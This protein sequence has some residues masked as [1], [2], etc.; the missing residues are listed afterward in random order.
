MKQD[1]QSDPASEATLGLLKVIGIQH[2][3]STNAFHVKFPITS[4]TIAAFADK[5]HRTTI[6][7]TSVSQPF[8]NPPSQLGK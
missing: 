7:S 6:C 4:D 5:V 3:P 8:V 2:K 1:W